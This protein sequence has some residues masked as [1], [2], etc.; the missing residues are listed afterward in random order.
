MFVFSP[1][2][3]IL[4]PP[5]AAEEE[6]AAALLPAWPPPGGA[7]CLARLLLLLVELLELYQAALVLY[8][9]VLELCVGGSFS[10]ACKC[11]VVVALRRGR[12][13]VFQVSLERASNSG[14]PV[15]VCLFGVIVL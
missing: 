6:P 2:F 10:T 3:N 1:G 7:C 11:R 12:M 15:T 13:Y 9:A 4:F 5:R 8:R 14:W